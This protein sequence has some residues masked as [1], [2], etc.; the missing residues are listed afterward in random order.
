MGSTGKSRFVIRICILSDGFV[1]GQLAHPPA[2]LSLAVI[3]NP[4]A[5]LLPMNPTAFPALSEPTTSF[6]PSSSGFFA[7]L[8]S[9]REQRLGDLSSLHLVCGTRSRKCGPVV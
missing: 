3:A 4:L 1:A 7:V 6:T 5:V 9:I 2:L 8:P